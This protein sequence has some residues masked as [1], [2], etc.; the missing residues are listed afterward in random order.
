MGGGVGRGLEDE[1]GEVG[2]VHE[3][4]RERWVSGLGRN[5]V[6][7]DEHGDGDGDEDVFC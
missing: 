2:E 7:F 3:R 6:V 5:L 4:R 1:V